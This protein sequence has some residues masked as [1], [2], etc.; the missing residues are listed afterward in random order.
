MSNQF[1]DPTGPGGALPLDPNRSA[2]ERQAFEALAAFFDKMVPFKPGQPL[3][4]HA[5]QYVPV[6]G[7]VEDPE[8]QAK[9][10]AAQEE[11]MAEKTP[12]E[13][14]GSTE[15]VFQLPKPVNFDDLP[16]D[17]QKAILEAIERGRE[18]TK[19]LQSMQPT[20]SLGEIETERKI[21]AAQAA[22]NVPRV[23]NPAMGADIL[24]DLAGLNKGD[25]KPAAAAPA[26]EEPP[27]SSGATEQPKLCPH[28]G[29][30]QERP[31]P[32]EPSDIDRANFVQAVLGQIPFRKRYE[33]LN[34]RLIVE[35]R[36]LTAKEADLVWTQ[37]GFDSQN[38]EIMGEG[39]FF[40]TLADYRMCLGVASLR[41]PQGVVEL[42]ETV[43][44]WDTEPL[45]PRTTKLKHITNHIYE[46]VLKSE[47]LRRA[48]ATQFF[49]FQR[50]VERLEAHVDAPDFWSAID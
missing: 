18:L 16:P 32:E 20:K 8:A 5:G 15:P 21:E 29:W 3:T 12:A 39:Q 30:D 38:N 44:D 42:P 34:G 33:L 37:T 17:R 23:A 50:L 45:P 19:D 4:Q 31:D 26:S 28:C 22:A 25:K 35:F 41:T 43:D 48:V 47:S 40:R 6:Q 10:K 13:I 9:L 14:L 11:A 27:T 1:K 36:N 49:R 7:V 46:N 2:E 24:A